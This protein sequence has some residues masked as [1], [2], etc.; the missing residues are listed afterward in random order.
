MKRKSIELITSIEH[1][2][3]GLRAFG[4]GTRKARE[5]YPLIDL[6]GSISLDEAPDRRRA[7]TSFKDWT[8]T[9]FDEYAFALGTPVY[10]ATGHLAWAFR[11]NSL[12]FVVPALVMIKALF[13][14]NELLFRHLFLPQSLDDICL[15]GGE[16][17]DGSNRMVSLLGTL[18]DSGYSHSRESVLEPLSWLVCF[19]SARGMWSSV[20]GEAVAGRL[21]LQLPRATIQT[22]VHGSVHASNFYVTKMVVVALE[23]EE[24]PLEFASG[25]TRMISFHASDERLASGFKPNITR[26]NSIPLRR[27]NSALS[28]AEWAE[29]EPIIAR[30]SRFKH[31]PRSIVDAILS[32]LSQGTSWADTVYPKGIHH[33]N[34]SIAFHRWS[35]DGRWDKVLSVIAEHRQLRKAA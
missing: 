2:E 3:G 1:A 14:P 7:L 29:L 31:S 22:V 11:S 25:H 27:G 12:R 10:G 17:V 34:A 32:K 18:R 4:V 16:S 23:A 33:T 9:S 24:A 15:F 35:K 26:D 20:L 8:L 5:G 28:D 6:A 21:G 30:V 19:P 13:R